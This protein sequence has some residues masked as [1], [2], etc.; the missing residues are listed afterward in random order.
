MVSNVPVFVLAWVTVR[1]GQPLPIGQG[2]SVLFVEHPTRGWEIPGGHLEDGESPGEAMIR[3]LKEE[4][5]LVGEI[6]RWNKTYYPKGWVAHIIVD[7]TPTHTWSV[8]DS[9]VVQ[10]RWWDEVPPLIEWT[11]QE[12]VDLSSWHCEKN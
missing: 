5:G 4:T 10:V 9:N 12:F 8:G 11:E 7:S 3:E 1:D 6:Q 2:G